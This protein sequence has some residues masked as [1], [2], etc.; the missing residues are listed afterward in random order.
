MISYCELARKWIEIWSQIWSKTLS[1]IWSIP[2]TYV[3]FFL[4]DAVGVLSKRTQDD[5]VEVVVEASKAEE[6][7]KSEDVGGV[8]G[9]QLHQGQ[10]GYVVGKTGMW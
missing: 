10:L 5:I 4:K 1:K 7:K 3:P 9:P 2:Y 6:E 8:D